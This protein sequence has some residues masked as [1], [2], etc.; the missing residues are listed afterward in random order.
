MRP[1]R[2]HDNGIADFLTTQ[3]G[4]RIA[5]ALLLLA[6]APVA[7]TFMSSVQSLSLDRAQL[8]DRQILLGA[9]LLF[10]LDRIAETG[11]AGATFADDP[12]AADLVTVRTHL[13][14]LTALSDDD[15]ALTQ[16]IGKARERARL[17]AQSVERLLQ[18]VDGAGS[19][20][21]DAAS[22][23][24]LARTAND[25]HE[26][27]G[28]LLATLID[29][30]VGSLD[31]SVSMMRRLASAIAVLLAMVVAAGSLALVVLRREVGARHARSSAEQA[32]DRARHFDALT[33]L[34]NRVRFQ[35][36][37]T[38]ALT[39]ARPIALIVVDLD[40]FAGINDCRGQAFGDAVIRETGHRVAQA[41][42][43]VGGFAA[44]TGGDRFALCIPTEE[45]S[46]L[47]ELSRG[48]VA[49]CGEPV[50]KG[51]VTVVPSVSLGIVTQSQLT[52]EGDIGYETLMR[53]ASLALLVA[54]SRGR[55][56]FTFYE[57]RFEAQ[58]FD[59]STL[60]E[61]LPP[62]LA[63]GVVCVHFQPK[64]RMATGECLGFEA[65]VHWKRR[66][67]S[68][69]S[70][71]LIRAAEN[72][73]LIFDLD[74][75]VLDSA[76]GIV[77]DWNRRRRTDFALSVNVSALGFRG[78]AGADAVADALARH[79]FDPAKLTVEI[80]ETIGLDG[81]A[82][83]E[84]ITTALRRTG[85]RI[86]IDEF[87][88]GFSSLGHLGKIAV[89]EIKIAP[90]LVEDIERNPRS[91]VIL[92]N[93][94]DL[95][96]TLGIDLTVDGVLRDSQALVLRDRGCGVAQGALYGDPRP[97]A[98]WLADL[99]YRGRGQAATSAA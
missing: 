68:V 77:S 16:T 53:V 8:G 89:D 43:R 42:N 23:K 18:V 80:S 5:L 64:I 6:V 94:V 71:D 65:L 41:A 76:I 32:A 7:Y 14:R 25:A 26:R 63:A 93:L 97:A 27:M 73:G 98:D 58:V 9:D 39:A 29:V 90:A 72:T 49:N 35:D 37:L 60:A 46:V 87:G 91:R 21:I 22:A 82:D 1:H 17:V 51:A 92:S 12:L 61:D 62:A 15:R 83:F 54:K 96:R 86:A 31:H 95:A 2:P 38:A 36:L 78:G 34:P 79:C 45:S 20:R 55:S 88:S 70:S 40:D 59:R 50:T 10:T 3:G 75:Y 74:R 48:L 85:C 52:E 30:N 81:A 33:G 67:R 84:C 57:S 19:P 69:P 24:G 4:L 47:D 56:Q 11:V 13:S 28:D 44:R 99:T 66:G